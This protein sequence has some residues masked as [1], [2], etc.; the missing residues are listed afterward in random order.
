MTKNKKELLPSI[1][2]IKKTLYANWALKV[3]Q[4]D[5]WKCALCESTENLTAHHWYVSDHHAHTARYEV[6]NGITLCYA[7]HIRSVHTRADY[8]TIIKLYNYMLK[9]RGFDST[10]IEH[11]R[12]CIADKF[13]TA[14]YRVMWDKFRSQVMNISK[15]YNHLVFQ[16]IVSGSKTFIYSDIPNRTLIVKQLVKINGCLHEVMVESKTDT[17]WRYTVRRMEEE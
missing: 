2:L 9:Y 16:V 7:C 17:G 5:G 12:S 13:T 14:S 11:L 8:V 3:K 10:T 1:S 6:S 15:R 4:A